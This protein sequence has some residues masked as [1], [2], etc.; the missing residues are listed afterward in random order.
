[1]GH[2]AAQLWPRARP[3]GARASACRAAAVTPTAR[4]A[5]PG[6]AGLAPRAP[7]SLG[8]RRRCSFGDWTG[9]S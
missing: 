4:W 9:M 2:G 7:A 1:M 5:A 3:G 6:E 8:I